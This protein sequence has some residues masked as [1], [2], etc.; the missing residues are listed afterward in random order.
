MPPTSP[1]TRATFPPT[2]HGF[3]EFVGFRGG[4]QDYWDWNLERNGAPFGANGRY[5]TDVLTD[6]AICFIRAPSRRALLPL[7]RLHRSSRSVP[8]TCRPAQA[9]WR[10]H[11]A[12]SPGDD[13]RHGRTHG[14]RHRDGARRVGPLRS[15]REHAGDVHQ[16]QRPMDAAWSDHGHDGPLQHRARRGKELVHKEVRCRRSSAG[17]PGSHRSGRFTGS[18]TSPI[19]CQPCSRWRII[20]GRSGSRATVWT[21]FPLLRGT[22]PESAT[23]RFWQWSRYQ[24]TPFANAAMRDGDWKLR[25]PAV[26]GLFDI[27][28]DDRREERL[29]LADPVRYRHRRRSSRSRRERRQG[30]P[31]SSSISPTTPASRLTS[32]PPT[33]SVYGGWRSRW[34]DGSTAWNLDAPPIPATAATHLA[35]DRGE[36]VSRAARRLSVCSVT[37]YFSPADV[38]ARRWLVTGRRT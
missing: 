24:P 2:H 27:L 18:H 5:L 6:E 29:L 21:C 7:C 38:A 12:D 13:R 10:P 14:R 28:P 32:P 26:P 17:R 22:A 33:R 25:Y 9:G 31:R 4:Y 37:W 36:L 15:R 20:A 19:G 34:P 3:H 16:R 11:T 30:R 23:P 35:E 8:G 1:T